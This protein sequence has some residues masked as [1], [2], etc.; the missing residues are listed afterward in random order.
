MSDDNALLRAQIVFR[1]AKAIMRRL[2]AALQRRPNQLLAYDEVRKHLHSG[3]PVYR[4]LQTVA[5]SKIAG[6]V[7][8]YRDFDRTFLPSQAKTEDRW[9]SIGRAH[10]EQV[11]LPPVQLYKIGDVYFVADGN[12][13]VSVARELGQEFIDAEVREVRVRVPLTAEVDPRD[14]E[15]IGEKADFLAQTHLDETRPEVEFTLT[16]PGGYDLLLEHIRTHRY[17]Q[18]TEWKREFGWEEAAAQWCDQVYMPMVEAI[19]SSGILKEFP[20]HTEGD[21]Y[22][23]LIEHQY[24]LRERYGIGIS[25]QDTVRSYASQFTV[26]TFKRLWRWLLRAVLRVEPDLDR[27]D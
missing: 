11:N 3:G 20:G 14:L 18:S 17:L 8:R 19:R 4:G 6:S 15:I 21:L 7:N 25:L 12:H 24:Y 26:R 27:L 1:R 10:F 5:I 13:R 2:W 16:I 9:E 23:W 22:I